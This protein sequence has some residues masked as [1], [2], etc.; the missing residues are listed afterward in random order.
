MGFVFN[1]QKPK[2][3]FIVHGFPH[4]SLIDL[5]PR[6]TNT[7]VYI[8][9]V[10]MLDHTYEFITAQHCLKCEKLRSYNS[11]T[12]RY[13]LYSLR[14]GPGITWL[15]ANEICER[16]GGHLAS[17]HSWKDMDEVLDTLF[18]LD[19]PYVL[20]YFGLYTKVLTIY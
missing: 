7:T 6:R 11:T 3:N 17:F 20:V 18:L 1:A 13:S 4:V 16:N 12:N 14:T 5:F 15:S 8:T 2:G 19:N 10:Q 9:N